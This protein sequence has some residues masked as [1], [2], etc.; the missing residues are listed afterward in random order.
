MYVC[1]F[2]V[3]HSIWIGLWR[4]RRNWSENLGRCSQG[5]LVLFGNCSQSN[6]KNPRLRED[7][8]AWRMFFGSR[9]VTFEQK[10]ANLMTLW[11]FS[12]VFA[13]ALAVLLGI[14]SL[15]SVTNV[16][17]WKE[18]AFVQSKLGW[19]CL[20]FACAH[21]MFYG[22]PYMWSP[23]CHVP[24]TFQV[25]TKICQSWHFGAWLYTKILPTR[26]TREKRNLKTFSY[27][28]ASRRI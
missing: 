7:A 6:C 22:W 1:G 28:V 23:S 8:L 3:S 26:I 4:T 15:P 17:T 24:P 18:F 13:Y 5:K 11:I 12:G 2:N 16:L 27:L 25:I 21:D 20:I 10:F 14:T 19:T 9:F